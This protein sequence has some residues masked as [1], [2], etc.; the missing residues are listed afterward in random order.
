MTFNDFKK[1]IE[2]NRNKCGVACWCAV[3]GG[4]LMHAPIKHILLTIKES[5]NFCFS[6]CY[7]CKRKNPSLKMAKIFTKWEFHNCPTS[8]WSYYSGGR[9]ERYVN[10]LGGGVMDKDVYNRSKKNYS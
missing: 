3:C 1:L 6:K 9:K 10:L 2:S 4:S 7:H 5:W 8:K